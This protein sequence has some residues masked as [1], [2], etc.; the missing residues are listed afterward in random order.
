MNQTS[1]NVQSYVQRKNNRLVKKQK[2]LATPDKRK[3]VRR[4]S[5]SK[6]T[7]FWTRAKIK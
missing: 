2:M 4:Y 6:L 5:Q 3:N 1:I 7:S